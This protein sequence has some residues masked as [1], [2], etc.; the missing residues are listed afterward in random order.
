MSNIIKKKKTRIFLGDL[1]YFN[2]WS[3]AMI[4]IPLNVA[5]VAS[6]LILKFGDEIEVTLFKDPEKLLE[7][8]RVNPP[9]VLGLSCLLWNMRLD[10]LV[11][12][13]MKNTGENEMTAAP[14]NAISMARRSEV[15]VI[16]TTYSDSP[17]AII[18]W[19][20]PDSYISRA[21]SEP[22]MSSP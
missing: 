8:A 16:L 19:S 6:Y 3:K 15:T 9:D 7:E 13:K 2:Q 20:S 10:M 22:P 17:S 21:M 11:F 5:Y 14:V 18:S 1:A 12:E 4:T